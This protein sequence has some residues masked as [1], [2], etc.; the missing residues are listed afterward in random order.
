MALKA[1]KSQGWPCASWR[2]RRM[3]FHLWAA[4][5]PGQLVTRAL[6]RARRPENQQRPCRVPAQEETAA[7]AEAGT[8]TSPARLWIG[9][10]PPALQK[11]TFF[12]PSSDSNADISR[13]HS[14]TLRFSAFLG[15][16]WPSVADTCNE[17]SQGDCR[18][19]SSAAGPWPG[20]GVF[21]M[22]FGLT[23]LLRLPLCPVSPSWM[24]TIVSFKLT[25]LPSSTFH[26]FSSQS[27]FSL[28]HHF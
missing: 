8:S 10:C 23:P 11:V 18:R 7:V 15:T 1:E 21:Q 16:L 2:P 22:P 9:W 6:A 27:L 3:S 13:E 5:E 26:L 14:Q 28:T 25:L 4:C 17:P 24:T 19:A 20:V 12:D